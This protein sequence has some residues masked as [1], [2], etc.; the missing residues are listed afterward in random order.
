MLSSYPVLLSNM[1]GIEVINSGI[2]GDTTK[3]ALKRIESDVISY[4]PMMVI[5]EFGA[6]DYFENISKLE[7]EDNLLKIITEIQNA[8]SI[9]I[10]LGVRLGILDDEYEKVFRSVSEKTG[11]LYIPNI[12]KGIIT[13]P[14]LKS[15]EIHPNSKGYNIMADRIFK[16]IKPILRK[17]KLFRDR[18]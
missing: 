5:I 9:T 6:N 18:N 12:L 4:K 3:D 1:S 14:A 10:I 13:N 16:K 8:G 17:K 11:S 7:T 2:S 15:D